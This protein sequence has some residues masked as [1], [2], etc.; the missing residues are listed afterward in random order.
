MV[1]MGNNVEYLGAVK[2]ASLF[3]LY[4]NSKIIFEG[5]CR[6]SNDFFIRTGE[7]AILRIGNDT[8]FGSGTK[9]VCIH[10]ITIGK[11]TQ[12]AYNSQILDSDFHYIH[13]LNTNEISP[14]EKEVHIGAFNWIGNNSTVNKGTVTE[15][16]TIIASNSLLNKNYKETY[17][18]FDILAGQPAK[19]I[20]SGQKRIFSLKKEEDLIAYFRKNYSSTPISLNLNEIVNSIIEND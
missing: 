11:S 14:R 12:L 1:K 7:N 20:S 6:F 19:R 17:E 15:D 10:R 4:P 2:G 9:L 16:Y 13:N 18:S 8:F 5:N 3:V